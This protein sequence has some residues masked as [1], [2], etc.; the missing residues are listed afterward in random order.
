MLADNCV[1]LRKL[2]IW[3]CSQ[4]SEQFLYGHSN[5]KLEIFGGKLD[6]PAPDSAKIV[7]SVEQ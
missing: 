4:I 5:D 3:G 7:L 1:A 2:H 6:T